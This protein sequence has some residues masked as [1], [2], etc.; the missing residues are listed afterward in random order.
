MDKT[1]N[2]QAPSPLLVRFLRALIVGVLAVFLFYLKVLGAIL[3]LGIR[4]V[5]SVPVGG[6]KANSSEP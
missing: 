2:T 5:K 6:A 4:A 3:K 1:T